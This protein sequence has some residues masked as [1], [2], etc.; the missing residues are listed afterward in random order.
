V[1]TSSSSRSLAAGAPSTSQPSQIISA[2]LARGAGWLTGAEAQAL[3][4]C[5]GL[6]LIPTRVAADVEA[7]VAAAAALGTPVV[8]KASAA[9]LL[10]ET[11]AGGVRL[12]L[13]GAGQIRAA[14]AE[15]D[16]AVRAAGHSPDGLVV[17]SLAPAGVELI[18]GVVNDHSFGPVLACG[19]GAQSPS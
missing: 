12:N 14:A 6:P 5:S 8:L 19:A 13:Q 4:A 16:A 9:G 17:Q 1:W 18:V 10:H 7:A 15:I 11:D 3:L 2:K